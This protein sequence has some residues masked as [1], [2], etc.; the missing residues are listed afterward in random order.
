MRASRPLG[1]FLPHAPRRLFPHDY[2]TAIPVIEHKEVDQL[3][4]KAR[5]AD[6]GGA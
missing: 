3:L 5:M 4:M 6:S 2:D 1:P